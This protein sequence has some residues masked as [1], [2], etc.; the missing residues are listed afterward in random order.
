MFD[1]F[2]EDTFVRD[3]KS[4]IENRT[5]VLISHHP[6]TLSLADRVFKLKDGQLFECETAE[7][8]VSK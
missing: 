3:I 8:I 2:S 4:V 5:V 7:V 6:Q 1:V